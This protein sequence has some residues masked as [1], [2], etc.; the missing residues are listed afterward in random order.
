VEFSYYNRKTSV[1]RLHPLC[2][3]LWVFA[4]LFGSIIINEPVFLLLLFFSTIPFALIGKIM[5]EWFSFIRLALLLSFLIILINTLASQHGSTVL[6]QIIGLPFFGTIKITLESLIFSLAMSLR[7]LST[8][9]AF[10]IITL[11]INPDDLLQT[12]LLLKFPYKT[13]FTTT[14]AI[15]FIPCLF[16]DLKTIQD[17]VRSRG[18]PLN[19]KGFFRSIIQRSSLLTPLLSNSL[20]RSV[21]SAE[22]MESRG[23]GASGKKTFYKHIK[24]TT[25][26]YFFVL[27][28]LFLFLLF[29]F[30]WWSNIGAYNYYPTLPPIHINFSYCISALFLVFFVSAPV[31]FSPLKKVIDLD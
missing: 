12:I 30:I 28:S 3:I 1:H 17:S 25:I 31:V 10:A 5:K 7:L 22:A 11:T 21:Q 16:S 13:V 19:T 27:L 15:R 14:V 23:F 6:Y 8:L 18:Y 24:I 20:E 29:S 2:K 4:V 9:S 26:D